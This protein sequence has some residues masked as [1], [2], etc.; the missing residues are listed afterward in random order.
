[1]RPRIVDH[2]HGAPWVLPSVT[3]STG[4]ELKVAGHTYRVA[5]SATEDELQR[6]ARIVERKL[7]ELAPS[8]AYHPQSMLLVAMS[9]A[10]EVEQ[11]RARRLAVEKRSREMLTTVLARVDA[12]LDMT[13]DRPVDS[14]LLA[15]QPR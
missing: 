11:E 15:P 1:M 14:E 5:S 6:L 3:M 8:S 4:V 12:A 9:L 7:R 13:G 2:F 10:F